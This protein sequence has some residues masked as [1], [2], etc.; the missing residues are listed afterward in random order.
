MKFLY[1][2]LEEFY[3]LPTLSFLIVTLKSFSSFQSINLFYASQYLHR[4][5]KLLVAECAVKNAVVV[6]VVFNIT[7]SR[8]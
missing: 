2:L 8:S 7:R 1:G 4:F 5:D 3:K 6:V